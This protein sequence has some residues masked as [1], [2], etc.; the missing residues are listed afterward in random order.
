MENSESGD[1]TFLT[2]DQQYILNPDGD[3][4]LGMKVHYSVTIQMVGITI[5][6]CRFR[7]RQ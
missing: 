5:C 1:E 4:A 2:G 7:T 3:D 6:F